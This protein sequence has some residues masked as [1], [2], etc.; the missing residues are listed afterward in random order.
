[1]SDSA[2]RRPATVVLRGLPPEIGSTDANLE[3]DRR[4]FLDR[5][6]A[7]IA[8]SEETSSTSSRIQARVLASARLLRASLAECSGIFARNHLLSHWLRLPQDSVDDFLE[9]MVREL[10]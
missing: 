8:E 10:H 6:D 5:L 4:D 2:R 7:F 9:R 3:R 1:M